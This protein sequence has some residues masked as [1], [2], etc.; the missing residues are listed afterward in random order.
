VDPIK[1]VPP[2]GVAFALGDGAA[3][4]V[5]LPINWSFLDGIAGSHG[6]NSLSIDGAIA[7]G[8]GEF[9]CGKAQGAIT[10]D[11][12]IEDAVRLRRHVRANPGPGAINLALEASIEIEDSRP[13]VPGMIYSPTQWRRGEMFL[14]ADHRLAYP[15]A[16]V[17]SPALER[18]FWLARTRPAERDERAERMRG[19][20]RYRQRTQLGSVG[21]RIDDRGRLIA[22]WPYAEEDRSAMLDA[23]GT[24]AVAFY[25]LEDGLDL[26][27]EYEFG[28]RPAAEFSEAIRLVV[29]RIASLA[30]LKPSNVDLNLFDAI[31]WRLDSAA[32]TFRTT[33]AGFSGFMLTFDPQ[34]GYDSEAKAFGASFAEH[35]MSGSRN[36]LE[37]GFTGRQLNIA[38]CLAKRDLEGW[39]ERASAVIDSFV[40][41]M[42]THSGWV[43]TLFDMRT[44]EPLYA[45]GDP[46]GLVM[47]Y[48]GASPVSGT[49]TR[50]MAEAGADLLLSAELPELAGDR[51]ASWHG[52][53]QRL[54]GFFVRVQNSDGSWFRAYAPD[55]TPIVGGD[56]FGEPQEA[57][58]TATSPVI[59]YLLAVAAHGDPGGKFREAAIRGGRYVLMH[60]VA[61]AEF[62]GGTLDNPNLVDKEAAFLVMRAL[63]ALSRHDEDP[64]W[65]SGAIAAAWTAVSWHSFWPVPTLAG[66]PVGAAAV[67]SLG[68]GGI[69][70]VWGVGV[71]D[72]YSLFF[73][74]DLARL[75]AVAKIPLFGRIAELIAGSSLELLSRPG[76]LYGFADTGMQP[77]GISFC[78][79][80]CDDG[81]ISLGDIWGGLAWPYTAGTFG[82]GDFLNALMEV[83]D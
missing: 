2:G 76:R 5:K 20:S 80:G 35:A 71:T 72:I 70:S 59:P 24:P 15:I 42:A 34:R 49:Y 39:R 1:V 46:R 54:A 66:T 53:C 41:R 26:V 47:H 51:A 60:Q 23:S 55:G 43:Y 40:S 9:A 33:P 58:R 78:S 36:I 44:D 31:D 27:L 79:Q 6:Y 81:L 65:L 10:D 45:C 32:K 64:A 18:L 37:Y 28:L 63:L 38:Y 22:R 67:R 61:P 11:W 8:V 30:E 75:G 7:I 3:I 4:E 29:G 73:A 74:G 57:A 21:F 17:W 77:E 56:W 48:L 14:F 16:S 62:R 82:L 25:P 19:A 52:V 12:S 69:N 83:A 13:F 68:W 50:M